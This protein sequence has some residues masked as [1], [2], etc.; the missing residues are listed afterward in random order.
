M[1]AFTDSYHSEKKLVYAENVGFIVQK[2][3]KRTEFGFSRT[4]RKT[5]DK[6]L[7]EEINTLKLFFLIVKRREYMGKKGKRQLN[8]L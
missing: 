6:V 2:G 4:K 8:Y 5:S 3:R 7:R 1:G